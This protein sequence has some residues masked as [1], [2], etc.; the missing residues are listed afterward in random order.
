MKTHKRLFLGKK[1]TI[2]RARRLVFMV[3]Y[4]KYIIIAGKLLSSKDIVGFFYCINH[5]RKNET[6]EIKTIC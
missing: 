1:K 6:K 5:E 4:H 3:G 2:K